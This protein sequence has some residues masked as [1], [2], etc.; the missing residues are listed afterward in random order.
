M[1]RQ[2][3]S[4]ALVLGTS[5]RTDASSSTRRSVV[6]ALDATPYDTSASC[7]GY[8]G[9][10]SEAIVWSGRTS[11]RYSPAASSEKLVCR[12]WPT[13]VRFLPDAKTTRYPLP[14]RLV[15]GICHFVRFAE[16]S[17]RYHPPRFTADASVLRSS[18]QSE[19]SPSS[20]MRPLLL[21]ARNS[22]MTTPA[23]IN[24]RCSSDS[25]KRLRR[26]DERGGEAS[27]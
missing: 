11:A 26:Q 21:L 4:T 27:V 22:L 19:R 20:S 14:A 15:E 18:I 16:S 8:V 9:L 6:I 24:S 25:N 3:L 12:G 7:A 1:A 17:V 5:S 2:V 23:A 13:T 10:N